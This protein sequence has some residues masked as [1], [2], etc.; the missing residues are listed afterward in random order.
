L[1]L[2]RFFRDERGATA[3]EYG[4]V[5]ALIFLAIVGSMTFVGE[6]TVDMLQR[7][8]AAVDAVI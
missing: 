2:R 6:E 8:A 1:L 7:I 3:I 5:V 4:L